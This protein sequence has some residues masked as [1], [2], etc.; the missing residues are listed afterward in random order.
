[1]TKRKLALEIIAITLALAVVW[2][3]FGGLARILF[4]IYKESAFFKPLYLD[5]TSVWVILCG[6][7]PLAACL[8]IA[9][10]MLGRESFV[11]RV[12]TAA[13]I[14]LLFEVIF[15]LTVVMG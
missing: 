12:H 15:F 7:F 9:T 6:T 8:G 2:L 1:M 3:F 13:V 14:T 5:R 10:G 11:S 4:F